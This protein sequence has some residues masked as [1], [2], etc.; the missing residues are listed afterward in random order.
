[1]GLIDLHTHSN[2]SDGTLSPKDLIYYA[3]SKGV[4]VLAL[5]DHDTVSGL[6]EAMAAA[7]LI[8]VD[9]PN[10]FSLIP[11]IEFA[12]FYNSR[13]IHILG[14]N[15]DSEYKGLIE[16]I[17]CA[18]EDRNRRNDKIIELFHKDGIPI[19]LEDLQNGRDNAA[20]TRAHFARYL[21]DH[22]FVADRSEAFAK[23]MNPG[24]KF[25]VAREHLE[26]KIAIKTILDAGGIPVLAHPLL[27]KLNSNQ[28][29]AL[30]RE[31]ISYGLQGLEVFYSSN[32]NN[33]TDYLRS[34]ANKYGLIM[35][36]GSDFHGSN[37]PDIDIGVGRGNLVVP[38]SVLNQPLLNSYRYL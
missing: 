19:R 10:S 35:T 13:D 2:A 5:T 28:I 1:M 7:K 31:L 26:P 21:I 6:A 20:I 29:E 27:Y 9:N 8:N 34:L 32:I 37:K 25:Y 23:Y 14:L 22:G 3:A 17:D 18:I 11:G 12:A 36:G 4:S 15:I 38:Q 16:I 24:C 33:D 30:L